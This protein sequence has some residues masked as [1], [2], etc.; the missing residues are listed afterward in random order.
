MLEPDNG[1]LIDEIVGGVIEKAH[2]DSIAVGALFFLL[3]FGD[4][5]LRN[6]RSMAAQNDNRGENQGRDDKEKET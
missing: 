3:Q 6:T 1:A 2:R 5:E 4:M